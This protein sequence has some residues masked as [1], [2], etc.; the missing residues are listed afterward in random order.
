MLLNKF[1]F[2]MDYL[3]KNLVN[4]SRRKCYYAEKTFFLVSYGF[5]LFLFESFFG[6]ASNLPFW[7]SY[8]E[9][10]FR[11]HRQIQSQKDYIR[12]TK[13]KISCNEFNSVQLLFGLLSGRYC[14]WF[15]PCLVGL[16]EIFVSN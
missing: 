10:D 1:I 2:D 8:N 6:L 7:C 9:F 4:N 3:S 13:W 15:N 16:W 11:S 14:P 5:D 12:V